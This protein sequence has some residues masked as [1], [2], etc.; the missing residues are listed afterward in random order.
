MKNLFNTTIAFSRE[1]ST[2]FVFLDTKRRLAGSRSDAEQDSG[3]NRFNFVS[4]PIIEQKPSNER[5]K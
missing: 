4:P 1:I 5:V 3:E 2:K